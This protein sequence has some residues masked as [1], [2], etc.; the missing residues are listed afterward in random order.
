MLQ[1]LQDIAL[2]RVEATAIQVRAAV[3]AVQYTHA[4]KGEGGKK[5]AKAEAAK[6][7]ASK[8]GGPPPPPRL[9]VNKK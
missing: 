7:A 8:F 2:G 6:A 1:L 4:K 9:V 3:A 5:D